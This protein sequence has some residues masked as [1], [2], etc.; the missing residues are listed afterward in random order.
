MKEFVSTLHRLF[1][2]KKISAMR[3]GPILE[4]LPRV[5]VFSFLGTKCSVK[6][7][8]LLLAFDSSGIED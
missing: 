4:G 2:H 7:L 3:A 5:I 1:N 8:L 6:I